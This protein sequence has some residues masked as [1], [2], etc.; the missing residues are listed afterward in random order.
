MDTRI[1]AVCDRCNA[2]ATEGLQPKPRPTRYVD[3]LRCDGCGGRA[4]HL[5]MLTVKE[6][7]A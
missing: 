3:G 6:A 1:F 7:T 5:Y 4:T 2:L